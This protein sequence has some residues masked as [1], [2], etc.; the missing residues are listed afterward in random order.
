MTTHRADRENRIMASV[1]HAPDFG[2][3]SLQW[4]NVAAPLS[5]PA[6]A[7]RLVI[8]DFWTLC[9]INCIQVLPTLRKVEDAFPE[10][11]VVIGVHSPKFSAERA[12]ENVAAAIARYDIRHPVVH[13][14]E[15]T[16]WRD[17]AVRAWPTL[18]FVSPDGYVMGQ[19]ASEPDADRLL[20][21]IGNVVREGRQ[22]GSIAG[23]ELAR[24]PATESTGRLRFPGKLRRLPGPGERQWVLADAG[25]HQIV[26]LADDGTERRRYGSGTAG[27]ADG[28]AATAQFISPQGLI[29]DERAI[30]V[31]DTFNHA[32]RRI[33]RASGVVSTL[34]GTGRRGRPLAAPQA[35][36][37]TALASVWD[38]ALRDGVLLFANAG[39]HQLG[40][41]DLVRG[42]VAA[43]AGTGGEDIVDGPADS[44]LLAQP[45]GL[46][47]SPD[48]N[49]LLFADSETSAVRR[50][51]L[52]P[53]TPRVE[54]LVGTGL[55]DFGHQNGAFE[56]A[57]LQ[58]P[59]GVT[60]LDASVALVADSYNGAIRALDLKRRVVSDF[61]GGRFQC[62][63]PICT[64]LGEPAG[65][66]ADEGGRV[67]LSDTNNHRILEYRLAEG[68]YRTW[69]GG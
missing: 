47:L 35:G 36:F 64:P 8:L 66:E 51:D 53:G 60:W 3:R 18:V 68:R 39:T 29:A 43:L 42:T 37:E 27:F 62:A 5:L 49:T 67:L 9:C 25:H 65:I 61:D 52:A 54:T 33:D 17:Y 46:A 50:L 13:D 10:E 20:D 58:H 32:I 19:V 44:A 56:Q 31:A 14:P 41:L 34:A 4:F 55:F 11:V 1:I 6:L 45:S 28:A 2:R 7:K 23:S 16:I 40:A 57:R 12:P 30:Y 22:S 48:G 69:A 59:L 26:V 38:V 15:M 63:D 24:A 21:V